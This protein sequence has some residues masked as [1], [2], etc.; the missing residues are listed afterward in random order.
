MVSNITVKKRLI[1]LF[2]CMALAVVLLILRLFYLQLV[3]AGDLEAKAWEQ[4]TRSVP[5]KAPRGDILDREGRLLA[6]SASSISI[7]GRPNHVEDKEEAARLLAPILE[8]SEERILERLSQKADSVYLKRKMN[9]E[10]VQ[11]LRKLNLRGITFSL[12]PKRYYP[13]ET[14]ASQLLGFVGIDEGLYGL[15]IKYEQE[16]KGADG[17]ALFQTDGKGRQVA[18]GRHVFVPPVE[19]YGLKLTIDQ[20]IQF[21]MEQEMDRVMLESQPK[22]IICMAVDP[23]T[24]EVLAIAGKPD[25]NPNRYQ[26]FPQETWKLSPVSNTF[27]PGSTFKLV[28][29]AAAIEEGKYR[30]DEGFF[31]SGWATVAG[32]KIG[33]WTRGRGGHGS[34]TFTEVVLGSCNPGFIALGQRIG[35]DKLMDYV[36]AFG[37]GQRSGID[38]VGEGTGIL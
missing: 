17:Q 25:F 36:K 6:G 8:M 3:I 29:L 13:H 16:L 21:I 5:A 22:G 26:E 20:N 30:A 7:L 34:L 38:V 1:F 2:F 24:G 11:E 12:E 14:L 19:G 31:C 33:C 32:S 9:E 15:E 28:T 4:W 37:F 27:E 18:Q 23:K 10:D 35:A